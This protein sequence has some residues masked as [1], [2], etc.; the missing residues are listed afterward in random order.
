MPNQCLNKDNDNDRIGFLLKH[1]FN[2]EIAI[3]L[4]P[5]MYTVAGEPAAID[6]FMSIYNKY[7]KNRKV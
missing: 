7:Q 4:A 2:L 3:F 6:N 5:K 1:Y